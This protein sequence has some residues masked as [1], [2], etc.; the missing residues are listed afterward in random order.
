MG[1]SL[2]PGAGRHT[3]PRLELEA[4]LDAVN[5]YRTLKQELDLHDCPCL[6]WSDS[7]IVLQSLMAETK[8]FP[9]FSRNRLQK[10]LA[11]TCVYD[12]RYVP[13]ESNPADQASRGMS[14]E[15]LVRSEMWLN[16]PKFLWRLSEYWPKY[17][18]PN[19]QSDVDY[20]VYKLVRTCPTHATV[21]SDV[22]G[23]DKLITYFSSLRRLLVATA[24][25]LRFKAYWKCHTYGEEMSAV[26]TPITAQELVNAEEALV[27]YDQSQSFP[28]WVKALAEGKYPKASLQSLAKLSP[29]LVNNALRVGGR[30][31]RA[32]LS[33]NAKHPLIVDHKRHLTELIID[34]YHCE[35]SGHLGEGH[36]LNQ[37]AQKYWIVNAK[38]A[39]KRVINKCLICR[40]RTAKPCQQIMAEL[41]EARLQIGEPPFSQSGVD[42]FGPLNVRVGRST[43]KRYGCLFT[44]LTTRAIHLELAIDLTTSSFINALRRF[45]ARRGPVKGL[46]SDNGTNF[47]GCKRTLKEAIEQWNQTQIHVHLRQQGINWIFS[48]PTGSNFGGAWERMIRTVRQILMDILPKRPLT[49]DVLHTVLLEV[50]DIVNS[51]P[52]TEVKQEADSDLP[53]TPNHLLKVNH[54]RNMAP[55][56]TNEKDLCHNEKYRS[57]QLLAD[58]FWKQWILEYPR[59]LLPRSKWLRR[60]RNVQ[61]DDIVLLADDSA[62]R[63]CWPLG[64]VI[65]PHFDRHGDVRSVDVKTANGVLRRPVNKLCVIIPTNQ[66]E[67]NI[68]EILADD[69]S[70]KDD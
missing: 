25:I 8:K 61:T 37:L 52:L 27:K 70:T 46:Y 44:C 38:S 42:Y 26:G 67:D 17:P 29:I 5:M 32:N 15:A 10:I 51:R 49:D 2:L 54:S 56:V 65:T 53:L 43:I 21:T 45:V 48:P 13:S 58:K 3:I 6:F 18:M 62:P 22:K 28:T 24:W 59:T 50:E 20:D 7:M 36:T 63:Q 16:G 1:K 33:F 69:D 64:R 34:Y 4:A 9:M 47:V 57:V 19:S 41:P 60:R 12:W 23:T 39:I 14:T 66:D 11:H 40:R 31:D 68:E 30:I 55:M 35:K